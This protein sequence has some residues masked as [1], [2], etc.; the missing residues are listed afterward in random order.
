MNNSARQSAMKSSRVKRHTRS[1]LS[2]LLIVGVFLTNI[3]AAAPSSSSRARKGFVFPE[4]VAA[5][6]AES[7]THNHAG[8]QPFAVAQEGG[9][10]TPEAEAGSFV[11]YMN[12]NQIACRDAS[13]QESA[14]I[15]T[16][17]ESVPL[18]VISRSVR[19]T[20]A[21]AGLD[22]VLRGT[23]Q[24]DGFPE[25]KAAFIRAAARW[26]ALISTPITVIVDVDYGTT[27]FGSAYS[28]PNVLGSASSQTL[29]GELYA[30]MRSALIARAADS[31]EAALYAALPV[32]SVPTDLG[33]TTRAAA[34]SANLR[35]LG[36]IAAVADP[37]TE[38]GYGSPPSIGFNSAF[39]FDFNPDDGI[40]AG[41]TDFDAVAVHEMGHMLGFVSGVGTRELNSTASIAPNTLDLFRFRSGATLGTFATA[42]RILSS[43][44][45][46][47]FFANRPE[48]GLSTGRPD[49][50]GG[51]AR[52]ASHWK[53]D[54]LSGIY[55]GIMDPNIGSGTRGTMTAND[56]TA[57]DTFGYTLTTATTCTGTISPT[58]KTVAATTSTGTVAVTA[59]C[60]WTAV[61]NSTWITLTSGASGTGNG[62]VGYSV[63]AN[64]T[65]AARAGTLT[66]A[67]QTFTVNQAA[68]SGG[69]NIALVS[70]TSQSGSIPAPPAGSG[71]LGSTQYTIQIPAGA[72]SLAV[73]LSG[74][75]DVDLFV[76]A[77]ERVA[78]SGGAVV[79][80]H[81]SET[82]TGSES[83]TINAASSPALQTTTYY[84]AVANFGAAATAFNVTAT[85]TY[86][87]TTLAAAAD[88][89]VQGADAFRSTNYGAATEM[90]VKRTLNP[91]AGRGR[92]G[93]LKF[94]FS[95]HTGAIT[96]AKLR[97][98]GKLSEAS[99][100]NVGMMLQKVADTSWNE[101]TMTWNNQPA[102]ESPTALAQI[103]V[104]NATAQWYE[105][106]LTAFIQAERAAGRNVVSF[107]LINLVPTG[108]SGASY[109]TFATKEAGTSTAPQ[110]VITP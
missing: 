96:N 92:R 46:H 70:G 26:E 64:T 16:R 52:Q 69:T 101:M 106:D 93:F 35:A 104:A 15:Q 72:L 87:Q 80:D 76:R 85:V 24:L 77:G 103:T 48:L 22:I 51:D 55:I 23:A 84:I 30:G 43:G 4:H 34:T 83:I 14:E 40:T 88:T 74:N 61:T 82:I 67:G 81:K 79:A 100:A 89:W 109:T 29:S 95:G 25:A 90:Q 97:V 102:V 28:S 37:T 21:A 32:G 41:K 94:D 36:M 49:G 17:Y 56:I 5:S 13:P 6:V 9:D 53:D 12:D 33:S 2:L 54:S 71:T 86:P 10:L 42:E 91:G 38:T 47:K 58:S 27:R 105:F 78:V 7:H 75:Q 108:S 68:G 1:C 3:V 63:A 66:I 59:T 44:G 73:N 107:R 50:T 110:L 57:F 62:T 65:T 45:E 8:A 19:R 39:S 20:Q 18:R 98:F 60:A 11:I 31:T 99:L